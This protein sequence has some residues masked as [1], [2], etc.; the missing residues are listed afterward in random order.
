MT[1]IKNPATGQDGEAD[2][3]STE[4][5][6]YTA[7]ST[8]TARIMQSGYAM[9][10]CS[11]FG[12]Y[13][14]DKYGKPLHTVTLDQIKAMMIDPPSVPKDQAQWAIFSHLLTR[15]LAHQRTSGVYGCLWADIDYTGGLIFEQIHLIACKLIPGDVWTYTSRSATVK[16]PKCRILAPLQSR[17]DGPHYMLMQRLLND[18]FIRGGV[19][20]DRKTETGN[21]ICFLPNRGEHYRYAFKGGAK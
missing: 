20:P 13:Q 17:V 12:K 14:T 10:F 2:N 16:N 9:Q 3:Q 19:I 4:Q 11:G 21:Q 5:I 6:D 7:E 15:N 8:G 18:G 1:D